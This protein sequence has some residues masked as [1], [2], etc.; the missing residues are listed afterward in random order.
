MSN[1]ALIDHILAQRRF[2]VTGVSRDPEKYGYL[3]YNYLKGE[4]YTVFA[5]NPN[6]DSI[7]DDPCYPSLDNVPGGIDCVVTVTPPHITEKT[8][9]EAGHLQIPYLWMQ[10]GSESTAAY[11]LARSNAMQV[12]SGGA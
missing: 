12:V 11:N 1:R 4:G 6:A 5:V 8:I 9:V 2:A 3:V 7:D 10:P